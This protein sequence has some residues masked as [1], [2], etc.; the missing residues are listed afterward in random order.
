MMFF[1]FFFLCASIVTA[2]ALR[3]IGDPL[4]AAADMRPGTQQNR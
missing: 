3:S 1:S 2:C 4:D